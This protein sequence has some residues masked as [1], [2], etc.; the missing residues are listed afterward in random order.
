MTAA[1]QKMISRIELLTEEEQ[2]YYAE[3]WM[4]EMEAEDAFDA[5][6]AATADQIAKLARMST[7]EETLPLMDADFA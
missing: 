6:I 3:M 2:D 5:K 7:N 4:I 1:L